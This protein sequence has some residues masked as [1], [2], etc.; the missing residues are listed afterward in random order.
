M[1]K[2]KLVQEDVERLYM[3]G[4]SIQQIAK[5]LGCVPQAVWKRV[6]AANIQRNRST[7]DTARDEELIDLYKEKGLGYTRCSKHFGVHPS[8]VSYA[9]KRLGINDPSRRHTKKHISNAER[10]FKRKRLE[11]SP[12]TKALRFREEGGR[13]Q[14]C[15]ETIPNS[16]SA[17]YHHTTMIDSGGDGSRGNCMVLHRKC[18]IDQFETLH[19]GRRYRNLL[20]TYKTLPKAPCPRC[21]RVVGVDKLLPVCGTC[22]KT[23]GKEVNPPRNGCT[24]CAIRSVRKGSEMG[25]VPCCRTCFVA[26]LVCRAIELKSQGRSGAEIATELGVSPRSAAYYSHGVRSHAG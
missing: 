2:G 3:Q 6:A 4:W 23:L 1:W 18:H 12:T 16:Y 5:E 14:W 22:R 7:W 9:C 11:F 25:G 10:T 24:F 21:H 20:A 13:C 15:H 8:V 19:N 26:S 17:T